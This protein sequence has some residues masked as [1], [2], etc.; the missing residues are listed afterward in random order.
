MLLVLF[1][2]GAAVKDL[3]PGKLLAKY[4][5]AVCYQQRRTVAYS[6]YIFKALGVPSARGLC[7]MHPGIGLNY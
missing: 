1:R 4:G 2:G 5:V 3:G 7:R 6:A